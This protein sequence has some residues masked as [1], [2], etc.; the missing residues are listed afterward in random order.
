MP[1]SFQL[2]PTSHSSVCDVA[3]EKHI[4]LRWF[5]SWYQ[6]NCNEHHVLKC[7]PSL[8]AD[9]VMNGHIYIHFFLLCQV[10]CVFL[11]C[12]YKPQTSWV[13]CYTC[14]PII[15][16]ACFKTLSFTNAFLTFAYNFNIYARFARN[17]GSPFLSYLMSHAHDTLILVVRMRKSHLPAI[18]Y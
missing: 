2:A 8:F 12:M 5:Q 17:D 15:K 6:V 3:I 14:S 16:E 7:K 1:L 10:H 18:D 9:L 13:S 11:A 4:S